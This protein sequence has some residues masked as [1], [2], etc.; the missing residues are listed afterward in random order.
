MGGCRTDAPLRDDV[1]VVHVVGHR[2]EPLG[3]PARPAGQRQA[4]DPRASA[5]ATTGRSTRRSR[6]SDR[7]AATIS[8]P[9]NVGAPVPLE[10]TTRVVPW[11]DLAAVEAA[12]AHG[13]VAAILTEPAM[14]NI[15]IV[16]PEDG[17]HTGLR[18]LATK[19]GAILMIDE[20]HTFSAGAG[21][22]TKSMGAG[23]RHLRHRQEHRRRD[24]LRCLRDQQ[25]SGRGIE[26]HVEAGD[27]DIIDVGGVGRHPRRQRAVA[28][29]DAS[30]AREV[31]TEDAFEHMIDLATTFT[32]GVQAPSTSSTCPGRS[33]SS[34]PEPSTGSPDPAPVN[35]DESAAAQDDDLDSYMHLA[36]CNR[37]HLDDAVP[38]H[39][40]DVPGHGRGRRRPAIPR[41]SARSSAPSSPDLPG[42]S[43]VLRCHRHPTARRR[44]RFVR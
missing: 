9:G 8:R 15:G 41:S 40:A 33:P 43:P 6:S 18:E 14:T 27:A 29:G 20:T 11:N 38:Q 21:G 36:M 19:Y 5:T 4:Q 1:L 35:G 34:A 31:L 25:R 26:R 39:G 37:G 24:P 13:D 32:A 44:A 42:T 2:R 30:H 16:L 10:Q 17:F 7:T 12:L 3:D 28:R 22:A 23:A